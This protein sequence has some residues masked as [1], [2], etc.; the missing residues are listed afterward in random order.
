MKKIN[1]K[2][3]GIILLRSGSRRI[4]NKNFLKIVNK[5]MF[6][7]VLEEANKSKIFHKIHL[8]TENVYKFKKLQKLCST[9]K[10]RNKVEANFL[11][12][13]NL[14]N[15]SVP[16]FDVIKHIVSIYNKHKNV[17]D[18]FC[19]I[20]A[21]AVFIESND[22][23]KMFKVFLKINN[24]YFKYGNSLQTVSKFPAPIEW[25]YYLKNDGT[26]IP[27][28]KESLKKTS[29]KFKKTYYDTGGLHFF[30]L[31]FLNKK[32]KK[33]NHGYVV[34]FLKSIDVDFEEDLKTIKFLKK[35]LI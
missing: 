20:Y 21:T 28:S 11:R 1:K 5:S 27:K 9:K 31:N 35:N 32:F 12:P 33:K 6:E 7:H 23:N 8:S 3:L 29:D 14:A 4:K 19:L 25:S 24:R 15:D 2:T 16:M 17:Y 34:E 30:N 10:Y 18:K 22:F 26:L 13:K